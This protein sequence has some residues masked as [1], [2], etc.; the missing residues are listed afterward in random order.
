MNQQL[1]NQYFQQMPPLQS[2]Y[3]QADEEPP[4]EERSTS[5]FWIVF[6]V[7]VLVGLA[8]SAFYFGILLPALSKIMVKV[9]G[10]TTHQKSPIIYEVV[11]VKTEE[12]PQE[13]GEDTMETEALLMMPPTKSLDDKFAEHNDKYGLLDNSLMAGWN[14]SDQNNP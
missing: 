10:L 11:P 5:F 7:F 8:L 1:Q 4:K 9:N 12:E 3:A 6:W 2:S 14:L 13:E